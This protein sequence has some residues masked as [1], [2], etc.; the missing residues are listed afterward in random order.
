MGIY[1]SINVGDNQGGQLMKVNK[2]DEICVQDIAN[3]LLTHMKHKE[4][5]TRYKVCRIIKNNYGVNSVNIDMIGNTL[6]NRDEKFLNK[7]KILSLVGINNE[8]V[9]IRQ[10]DIIEEHLIA[11]CGRRSWNIF[12][13]YVTNKNITMGDIADRLKVTRQAV[14]DKIVIITNKLRLDK[15]LI[16]IKNIID[17]VINH[18]IEQD[19][20]YKCMKLVS[21]YSKQEVDSIISIINRVFNRCIHKYNGYILDF[22]VDSLI[23]NILKLNR[24]K[25]IM[26]LNEVKE[27]MKALGIDIDEYYVSKIIEMT[28]Y[29]L[30]NKELEIA[31]IKYGKM[32]I[33]DVCKFILYCEGRP[34]HYLDVRKKYKK[35]TNRN[36]SDKVILHELLRGM[37][38]GVVRVDEGTYGLENL[39]HKQRVNTIDILINIM[40]RHNKPLAVGD[41][42]KYVTEEC[43]EVRLGTIHTYLSCRKQFERVTRGVYKIREEYL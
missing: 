21:G 1:I 40:R 39:G 11:V 9:R 22:K 10:Y 6:F 25:N 24:N 38:N 12:K 29:C 23:R 4:G 16:Q 27:I 8:T 43:D 41:I 2:Y 34:M 13:E 18:M 36:V 42:M 26:K 7:Y 28:Q 20:L 31:Y 30:Y 19:E 37:S 17:T 5:L 15:Q 35:I 33:L 3:I 32:G 14:G